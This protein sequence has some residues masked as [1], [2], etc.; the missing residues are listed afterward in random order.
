MLGFNTCC[1]QK[2][3]YSSHPNS[4]TQCEVKAVQKWYLIY[5]E[6]IKSDVLVSLS[7]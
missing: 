1:R 4:L 3:N 7:I 5:G 6:T 2:K